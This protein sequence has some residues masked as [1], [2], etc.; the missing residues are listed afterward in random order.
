MPL[1]SKV[2]VPFSIG[3]WPS[4]VLSPINSLIAGQFVPVVRG[5]RGHASLPPYIHTVH[6]VLYSQV[7][8]R[9]ITTNLKY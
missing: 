4:P 5:E 7:L 8:V 6:T 2:E 1:Y 9:D 3:P